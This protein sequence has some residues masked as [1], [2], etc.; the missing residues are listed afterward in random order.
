MGR[1]AEQRLLRLVHGS[2]GI[3]PT[4]S[5]LRRFRLLSDPVDAF[6]GAYLP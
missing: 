6:D 5:H 2:C 1:V 4:Q 3:Q